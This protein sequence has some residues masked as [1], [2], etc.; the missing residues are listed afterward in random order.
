MPRRL[1]RFLTSGLLDDPRWP[2]LW[3][4]DD[5]RGNLYLLFITAIDAMAARD[6]ART[7]TM[8]NIVQPRMADELNRHPGSPSAGHCRDFLACRS[9]RIYR[10]R[11][12]QGWVRRQSVQSSSTPPRSDARLEPKL[13]SET[14][15]RRTLSLACRESLDLLEARVTARRPSLTVAHGTQASDRASLKQDFVTTNNTKSLDQN[16]L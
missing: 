11:R 9:S 15:I 12:A 16:P 5:D 7:C 1:R 13:A 3:L 10:G 14:G 6:G 2:F 8:V 4:G